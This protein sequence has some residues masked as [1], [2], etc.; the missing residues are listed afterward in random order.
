VVRRTVV[1][2]TQAAL[3]PTVVVAIVVVVVPEIFTNDREACRAPVF[4]PAVE[5]VY[6]AA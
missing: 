1:E 6:V 4:V 3:V 5:T 2:V